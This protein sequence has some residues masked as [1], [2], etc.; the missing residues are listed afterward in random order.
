[1]TDLADDGSPWGWAAANMPLLRDAAAD[2]AAALSGLFLGL[3]LHLEPKTAVLVDHLV[4][5]GVTVT[6]TGS[7]GTSD[8]ATVRALRE[9]GV[10][11]YADD[12]DDEAAHRRHVEAV[13]AT[14]PDLLLDN[15]AD[16][17]SAA[18]AAGLEPRGATEETTTGA[19]R[20]RSERPDLSFPVIV[21][22]DS[23]LKLLAENEFG[24]GQS[25]VQGFM[26]VTNLMVPGLSA[27]V[28][29]YGPCGQGVADTLRS[30]GAH[31]VVVE[32]DPYRALEALMRGHRVAEV[33]AALDSARA[34]FLATGRRDTL[35]A[36]ATGRLR[37]GSILV[38][39]SH[40]P[41]DVDVDRLRAS[42]ERRVRSQTRY[43][44]LEHLTIRGRTITLCNEVRMVNLSGAAGNPIEAMDLGL[45][46]QL[47]SL[48]YLAT[49]RATWRG[50]AAPPDEVDRSVAAALVEVRSR[51]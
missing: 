47:R 8:P 12:A 48:A 41:V 34:V 29:G 26:N 37:D 3:C 13:V 1:M 35:D 4:H 38:G 33:G 6:A 15:G 18:V 7:P 10:E 11:V 24:V 42:A 28:L 9:L 46:L 17:I 19:Q 32:P 25:V 36:D 39:V 50:P 16:L 23:P 2:H 22:N 27:A 31:V 49:G 44:V 5:A 30:L 51:M 43:G 40:F 14:A 20:L 21:I 45:T